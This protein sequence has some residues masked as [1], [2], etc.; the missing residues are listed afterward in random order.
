MGWA[1]RS[2]QMAVCSECRRPTPLLASVM[3]YPDGQ[4]ISVCA[5]CETKWIE[6]GFLWP[7]EERLAHETRLQEEGRLPLRR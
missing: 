5:R 6:Q 1:A 4:V 3:L 7:R 2:K